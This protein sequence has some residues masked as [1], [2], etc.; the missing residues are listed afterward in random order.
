M[1]VRYFAGGRPEDICLVHGVSHSEVFKS[2]WKVVDAVLACEQLSFSFPSDHEKQKELAVGFASKSQPGFS[3]CCGAINGMLLWTERF[4]DE[5]R[6]KAGCASKKFFCG[7]KHKFGLNM[8]GTCDSECCFLDVCIKHPASTSDYLSFSSSS[9]YRQLEQPDFLAAGLCIFGDS[10]YVNCRYF[11]TPYKGVSSGPKDSFNFYH[12][13]L[14]IRIECAF[15][16][17]VSRWGILRR[18]IPSKVGW[19]QEDR[20]TCLL[21]LQ[22]AQLLHQ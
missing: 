13:Q 7:R 1:A 2:V 17:L 10:A 6:A 15:G 11:T 8:Q 20:L 3:N 14:R 9:L 4:S 5:E 19:H 22:A 21:S 18:T 16:Q 12:S